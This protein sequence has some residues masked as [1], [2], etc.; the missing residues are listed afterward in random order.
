MS[1][2]LD[3]AL[4]DPYPA[5]RELREHAP[6]HLTPE[7]LWLVSRHRDVRALLLHPD[8]SADPSSRPGYPA[9]AQEHLDGVDGPVA[10]WQRSMFVFMDDPAHRRLRQLFQKAFTPASITALRPRL[11]AAADGLMRSAGDEL[12]VIEDFAL[13]LTTELIG[14][15]LGVPEEDRADCVRR[16]RI[17]GAT[18]APVVPPE[19]LA[20]AGRALAE[21]T[22]YFTA[23][24]DERRRRPAGDLLTALTTA[25][26]DGETMSTDEVVAS[27]LLLFNAGHETTTALLGNAVHLLLE[28]PD[29]LARLRA[30]PDLLL[31]AA[32]EEVLRYEPSFQYGLV[33]T[34]A[35]IELSG[36]RIPADAL[37]MPLLGAANRDPDAFAE[38]ELF[39][40]TRDRGRHLSFGTGVHHCLGAPLARLEAQVGLA[41]LLAHWPRFEP[42]PGG[43]RRASGT[44]SLRTFERL[45]IR[46]GR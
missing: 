42:V 33:V 1:A 27:A 40:I 5:Y 12:D 35:P 7:G 18:L 38:P 45:L 6:V 29:Q 37:V 3:L 8:V 30:A 24:V 17:T 43:A 21:S 46:K 28:H 9:W 11:E 4:P 25:E 19:V 36:E 32:V 26:A 2:L 41:A 14:E 13:P 23:L 39:L 44:G 15:L 31:P 20:A 16:S 10:R 34:R 22:A